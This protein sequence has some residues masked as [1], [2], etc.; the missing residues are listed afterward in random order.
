MTSAL[1]SSAIAP[2][3]PQ[4]MDEFEIDNLELGTLV[5][6]IEVRMIPALLKVLT[7]SSS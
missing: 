5:V 7:A 4:L 6:T 1:A 3:V 2:A